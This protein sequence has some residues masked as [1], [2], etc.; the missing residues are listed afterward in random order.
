MISLPNVPEKMFR[1][2][3]EIFTTFFS[4]KDVEKEIAGEVKVV[5]CG[6][7]PR[8]EELYR[9]MKKRES[10]S[11]EDEH[12][13]QP[14]DSPETLRVIAFPPSEEDTV[15]LKESHVAV[16]IMQEKT[17]D[18][19]LLRSLEKKL[20]YEEKKFIW[21]IDGHAEGMRR[22]EIADQFKEIAVENV[23]WVED[24]W[25]KLS[26][27]VLERVSKHSL[28]YA[29]K[30]SFL[31]NEMSRRLVEKTAQ[32]NASISFFS[33]LP[34]NIPIIGIIIGLLAVTGET[35][36]M[37]A[38]QLRMCLRIAGMYGYRID[39]SARMS[40]LWPVLAGAF[41]WRTI[42]RGLAGFIPGGGPLLKASIAY[43]GTKA[44]GEAARWF[45]RDGKKITRDEL[46]EIY[47]KE[48][49]KVLEN[50]NGFLQKF[51]NARAEEPATEKE[52]ME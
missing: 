45:Y 9:L 27:M 21:F 29:V 30:F 49:A 43:A 34:T 11:D 37:T 41:G 26:G 32:E 36:F 22:E 25:E 40:E 47:S 6:D 39:F 5:L 42:A 52:K 50:V 46:R 33:S 13:T 19:D 2:L 7:S 24:E 17:M 15:F 44:T 48:K 23:F 18:I 1:T 10:V 8:V 3:W 16:F 4:L 12:E 28:A 31:R 38:N 14:L 35:L 20:P 51:K